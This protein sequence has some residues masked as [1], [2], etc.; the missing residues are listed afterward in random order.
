MYFLVQ[1]IGI[2]YDLML[3]PVNANTVLSWFIVC[4]G[5][6]EE[7][8]EDYE[9]EDDDDDDEEDD[10]DD[11]NSDEEAEAIFEKRITLMNLPSGSETWK[12]RR[13]SYIKNSQQSPC[14]SFWF[15]LFFCGF[16]STPLQLFHFYSILE[17]G[18]GSAPHH[19]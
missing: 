2:V 8:H 15:C 18:D 9:Y 16:E 4:A 5:D 19:L 1:L 14:F 3:C 11:D 6:T 12:V 7:Y 10:D 13:V 17:T